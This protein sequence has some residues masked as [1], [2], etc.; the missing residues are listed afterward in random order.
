MHPA[1]HVTY[2]IVNFPSGTNQIGIKSMYIE[3]W[4]L[5]C[6]TDGIAAVNVNISE[7]LVQEPVIIYVSL[8]NNKSCR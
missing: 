5:Q 2:L 6:V 1:G 8:Y 4:S 3:S 7:G